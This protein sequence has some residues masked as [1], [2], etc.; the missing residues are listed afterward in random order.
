MEF[1]TVNGFRQ[2]RPIPVTGDVTEF[3]REVR[4][5]KEFVD[6]LAT[7]PLGGVID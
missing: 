2:Y 6:R 3:E 4:L 7:G 1:L 5:M